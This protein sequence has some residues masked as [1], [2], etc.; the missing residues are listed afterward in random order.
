[1]DRS[2]FARQAHSVWRQGL[3]IMRG[4]NKDKGIRLLHDMGTDNTTRNSTQWI[5]STPV[6]AGTCPQE[7][8]ATYGSDLYTR[9][10]NHCMILTT[11]TIWCS[12]V[13][14]WMTYVP[15][16]SGAAATDTPRLKSGQHGAENHMLAELL[17]LS[18]C[19]DH[20]CD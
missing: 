18:R 16:F 4:I 6:A 11:R 7:P 17:V 14:A 10:V 12:P 9:R 19:L 15:P 20:V 8:D 2:C 3:T 5:C 1:M 13:I